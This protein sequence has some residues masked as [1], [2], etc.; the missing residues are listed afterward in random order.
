MVEKVG[1]GLG[2]ICFTHQTLKYNTR[3]A[4]LCHFFICNARSLHFCSLDYIL[5]FGFD[6]KT[7]K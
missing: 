6:L 5:D 4:L 1:L 7:L 3:F 2:G